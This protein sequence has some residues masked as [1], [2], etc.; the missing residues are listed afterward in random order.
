MEGGSKKE[1]SKKGKKKQ[2]TEGKEKKKVLEFG[3]GSRR[4]PLAEDAGATSEHYFGKRVR[5]RLGGV[6]L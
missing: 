4:R 2:R 5:R 1:G 6:S 3:R